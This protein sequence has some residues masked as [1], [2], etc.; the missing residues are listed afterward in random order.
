[1][2]AESS[3][4]IDELNRRQ[5]R[6]E[7][8]GADAVFDAAWDEAMSGSQ[9]APGQG[10]RQ[11]F[12][13]VAAGLLA[14]LIGGGAVYALA[15]D[16]VDD[17]TIIAP[18]ACAVLVDPTTGLGDGAQGALA[19]DP[20]SMLCPVDG[21]GD[22]RSLSDLEVTTYG[23]V[24]ARVL[25]IDDGERNPWWVAEIIPFPAETGALP[26]DPASRA[27]GAVFPLADRAQ[28]QEG[29]LQV[30]TQLVAGHA[31]HINSDSSGEGHWVIVT[32]SADE[33]QIDSRASSAPQ[34]F[35]DEYSLFCG[36]T[37]G[38]SGRIADCGLFNPDGESDWSTNFFARDY[39]S[40]PEGGADIDGS[41]FTLCDSTD[42]ADACLVDVAFEFAETSVT[43]F[44][45]GEQFFHQ[46]DLPPLPAELVEADL[47]AWWGVSTVHSEINQIRFHGATAQR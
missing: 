12:W 24:E 18:A 3:R 36:I 35:A 19:D 7:V 25:E 20:V 21:A 37:G 30:A 47:T 33:H 2:N 38:S 26:A 39:P 14:L 32:Q 31:D 44:V 10:S 34:V 9:A 46:A 45:D 16:Q 6:G 27:G 15:G 22:G 1:M 41:F 42:T 4:I 28:F 23:D 5:N 40:D 43:I 11:S 13:L 8:R 29:R 17:E